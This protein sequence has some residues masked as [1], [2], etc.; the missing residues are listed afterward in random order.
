MKFIYWSVLKT[1]FIL[2]IIAARHGGF[3]V[4]HVWEIV[5]TRNLTIFEAC[6]FARFYI[7]IRWSFLKIETK[8]FNSDPCFFKLVKKGT[9]WPAAHFLNCTHCKKSD[10]SS[11][12]SWAFFWKTLRKVKRSFLRLTNHKH[13]KKL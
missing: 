2:I 5:V 4:P 1:S 3:I 11:N 8:N 9:I 13:K 10:D 6:Y 12:H 7:F